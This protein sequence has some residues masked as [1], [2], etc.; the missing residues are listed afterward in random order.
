MVLS[1]ETWPDFDSVSTHYNLTTSSSSSTMAD[2]AETP[3][4]M[5]ITVKTP[6]DKHTFD[7]GPESTVQQVQ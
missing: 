4:V 5:K 2:S 1:I 7:V 3:N 6:K